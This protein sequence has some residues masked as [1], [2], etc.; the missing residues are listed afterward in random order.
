MI[1]YPQIDPV[2]I[3]LGPL[4]IHWYGL[5]YL[6][7]FSAAW[8]L[9]HRRAQQPNSGWT[10]QQVSDLIFYG[11][12]GVIAG[13]R[14]GYALFYDFS[15]FI[16]APWNILMLQK[17]GMSFHGGALGVLLAI[18]LF[19]RRNNKRFLQAMDF[20]VPM[21]PIGLGAGRIGNFIN[22]ELWGRAA[23]VPWA[24]VF[25]YDP[26][27]ITRHPSQLYQAL[28]EGL[29]LFVVLWLFS[30]K[31][32]PMGAVTGLFGVGYGVSRF[33]VEFFRE[34]D[35]HLGYIAFDW[36]TMGQ[37]LSVPLVLVGVGLMVWG[38]KSHPVLLEGK[39]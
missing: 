26:L 21:V 36:L 11:A 35:A 8:W 3:S 1:T 27:Q 17:G 28:G 37:L 30:R 4:Q 38:Y 14:I 15:N 18:A 5:M 19:A 20:G 7:G 16:A 22:G 13:G 10:P 2:A 31:P 39:K 34:P 29:I 12:I 24:M 33:V 25:P 6:L 32:R 23:D 9:C